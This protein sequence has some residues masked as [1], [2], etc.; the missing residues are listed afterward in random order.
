MTLKFRGLNNT[1][2]SSPLVGARYGHGLAGHSIPWSPVRTVVSLEG[3]GK[4]LFQPYLH[5]WQDS[6]L[7]FRL[8]AKG[9]SQ[10]PC[11]VGLFTGQLTAWQLDSLK[12]RHQRARDGVQGRC[13]SLF[14]TSFCKW[15]HFCHILIIRSF[16]V[17]KSIPHSKERGLHKGVNTSK[18]GSTEPI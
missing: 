16:G 1:Y 7:F 3:L 6:V 12:A 10:L 4:I 13:H 17:I 5:S 15:H 14:V 9:L 18:K 8:L 11:H 2:L